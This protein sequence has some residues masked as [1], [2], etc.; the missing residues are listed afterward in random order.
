MAITNT[1]KSIATASIA[2]ADELLETREH[3]KEKCDKL[4]I[5]TKKKFTKVRLP[6]I[7]GD[8]D[9]VIT[10]WLNGEAFYLK[11]GESYEL[12]DELIAILENANEL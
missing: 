12:P 3:M 5:D 10:I 11:R 8:G 7:R 9:D 4:G 6:N 1:T 2:Y